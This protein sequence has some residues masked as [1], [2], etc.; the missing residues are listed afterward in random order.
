ML[1][2]H[3][4]QGTLKQMGG[5]MVAHD[6]IAPH[7]IDDGMRRLTACNDTLYHRTNVYGH[8]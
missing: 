3:V 2:E 8:T 1:T 6:V 7:L 4:A 5:R